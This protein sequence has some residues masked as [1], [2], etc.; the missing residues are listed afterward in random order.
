MI[1]MDHHRLGIRIADTADP[2]RSGDSG[3]QVLEFGPERRVLDVM[4]LPLDPDLGVIDG[5]A[6]PLRSQ[7]GMIVCAVEDVHH[8]VTFRYCSEIASH[9]SSS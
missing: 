6:A 1:G 7:M 3:D 9:S 4:D 8:Y 5:H 2:G